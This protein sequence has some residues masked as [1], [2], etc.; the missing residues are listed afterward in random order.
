MERPTYSLTY[1]GSIPDAINEARRQKKLFVVY[2]SGE[3]ENSALL[4]QSTWV[5]QSVAEIISRCCIFLHLMQGNVEASQFSAIYPQKSIPSISAI[6]LNGVMLWHHEGYITAENLK[7]GI[8]RAWATLNLQETFLTAALA[9]KNTGLAN[10]SSNIAPSSETSSSSSDIPT[11]SDKTTLDSEVRPLTDPEIR[12]LADPGNLAEQNLEEK[13]PKPMELACTQ[14]D[15]VKDVK[16]SGGEHSGSA[17]NG[18]NEVLG[19]P[20][21]A[22]SPPHEGDY[23]ALPQEKSKSDNSASIKGEAS[24]EV[25]AIG[26][27]KQRPRDKKI[28]G[29]TTS[30]SVVKSNDI[31]FSIRLPNGT[32]LQTKLT[33]ADMLRDVKNFVDGNISEIGSYDLAVPYPRKLFSEQDMDRTLCELGFASREALIVVPHRQPTRPSRGQSSSPISS[34]TL[35]GSNT[36]DSSGGYFSY[37]KRILSYFNPLSY[38]RGNSSSPNSEPGANDGLWQYRP[39]PTNLNRFPGEA[40]QPAADN[41]TGNLRRRTSNRPFGSNI[42]T[43]RHDDDQGPSGDRNVFWNGNSTQ[44]GGD[45]KK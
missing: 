31:Q 25:T 42:H 30:S 6:G 1:K 15:D 26:A 40:S 9:S 8:G 19:E 4:E 34:D 28:D 36:E 35:N 2:I 39:N 20:R 32:S 16:I 37:V 41:N 5:D 10:S 27:E 22:G 21:D 38:F 17:R 18:D 43:L 29:S 24:S 3:D 45:D 33:K 12:P 14:P 11:T 23:P 44:F 7:E 13:D